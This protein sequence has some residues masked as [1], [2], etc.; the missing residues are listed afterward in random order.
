ME[1]A[2]HVLHWIRLCEAKFDI[3]SIVLT[4]AY[5]KS[6]ILSINMY[7]VWLSTIM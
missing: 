3:K 5:L 1:N 7:R 2:K 4:K 6:H